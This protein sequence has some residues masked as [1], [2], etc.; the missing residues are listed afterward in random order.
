MYDPVR[1]D[2]LLVDSDEA[3]LDEPLNLGARLSRED[4][5]EVT[6]D[7][8]AGFFGSDGEFVPHLSHPPATDKFFTTE[9]HRGH[10]VSF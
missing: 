6:V 7:A 8:D 10:R 9:G 5:D 3:F 2:G 1:P 4:P